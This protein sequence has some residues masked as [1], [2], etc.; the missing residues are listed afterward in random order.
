V[1]VS[2]PRRVSIP[3]YP[4]VP[5]GHCLSAI[6]RGLFELEHTR[7]SREMIVGLGGLLYFGYGCD[8]QSKTYE[9]TTTSPINLNHLMANTGVLL[10]VRQ[11]EDGAEAHRR[12][13]ALLDAG[14]L[15]PVMVNNAFCP[16]VRMHMPEAWI[17]YS[18]YHWILVFGYDDARGEVTYYDPGKFK[19]FTL[20]YADL[21]VARAAKTGDEV[22]DP[23]NRWLEY[24]FP[25]RP[26]SLPGAVRMAIRQTAL[27]YNQVPLHLPR[28][29]VG[30]RGLGMFA[31]QAKSWRNVLTDDE[32]VA[33][34]T[35]AV[36]AINVA[37]SA[38]GGFRFQYARFLEEAAEVVGD[39]TLKG[40][41]PLFVEAGRRWQELY[42]A[43]RH[44][45]EDPQDAR[46]WE[47]GSA[48]FGALDGV[49]AAEATALRELEA[50]A[51][52]PSAGA[53]EAAA[54]PAALAV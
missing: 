41:A 31:R 24:A 53:F 27:Y 14:R 10:K 32:L 6:L 43:L 9:I 54:E 11:A 4:H 34:A 26:I 25:E 29:Y 50:V 44:V 45:A 52:H 2:A 40:L 39:E 7:L 12:L 20:S 21:R 36:V 38:K 17:P 5:G 22:Y 3:G 13:I 46:M 33:N 35:R 51:F 16:S 49:H 18:A 8:L 30:L 23:D 19:P 37:N 15:V 28:L 48:L 1:V 42:D 47:R